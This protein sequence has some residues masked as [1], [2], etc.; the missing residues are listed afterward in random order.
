MAKL[1]ANTLR[2]PVAGRSVLTPDTMWI[3]QVAMR[4]WLQAALAEQ[5][6]VA[7]NLQF[8]TPGEFVAQA[9]NANLGPSPDDLDVETLHWRLYAALGD[10]AVLTQPAM[11]TIAAHLTEDLSLIH[12]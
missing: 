5:F 8:L 3:P 9:L 1:L 6:V 11:A 10:A 2:A 12:I 7:A 4:R